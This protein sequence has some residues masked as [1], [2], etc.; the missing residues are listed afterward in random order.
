M[1]PLT[2]RNKKNHE[3]GLF[4]QDTYKVN[5]RLTLDYGLRWDYFG[6]PTFEDGLQYNWDPAT[7]NVIVPQAALNKVSPLYPSTIKVVP[8]EAVYHSKRTNFAPRTGLAYRVRSQTVIRGGYG[9]F[10]ENFSTSP[11]YRLQGTGPF[12]LGETFLNSITNG[13]P[14][15]AF[16]SPYPP[17]RGRIPSQSISG[18][19]LNASN[20]RIHQFN[21]S[22]EHQI[23]DIGLRL[24]YIGSRSRGLNYSLS[25]NKP[26]PSMIP[27]S[28]DRRPY[29]Q[30]VNTAYFRSDGEANYNALGFEVQRKFS[31]SV[32]FQ[33]HWDWASNMLN[34]LNLENPYAPL[35]WNRDQYTPHHRVSI[36]AVWYLPF[37]QGKR[38]MSNAPRLADVLFGGW[39][40]YYLSYFQTG[41]WFT[42]AFDGSD[43]SNTRT[44]GGLP[45]RIKDGNLPTS[46]R[47]IDHWFDTSAFVPPPI[48]RFGNS[49][50]NILEG[51][52][53]QVHHV[54]VSK[55]HRITERVSLQTM[56]AISN[57][58]NHPNFHFPN[59]NISAP[60]Q[61]GV[62]DSTY[63][64]GDDFN[65]EK[66]ANRRMEVRARFEF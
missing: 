16:P 1:D 52:G 44:F 57:I 50:V 61:A 65:L 19:P 32:T 8:G 33:A 51:P 66:A 27:F 30:F 21:V 3:L 59:A 55:R 23:H 4:F 47:S 24:S 36:N 14:L 22:L 40:L 12:Q 17:G 35:S 48:G 49:G 54:T 7:G 28:P 53:L 58:L 2:D 34:N 56:L 10:T 18:F 37:G 45:D 26:Q 39:T 11:Y 9:I 41:S 46:Q 63:G 6:A 5:P 13:V 38:F 20:G 15:F 60:G 64:G 31:N 62:I 42:P 43:P 25:T 29:P